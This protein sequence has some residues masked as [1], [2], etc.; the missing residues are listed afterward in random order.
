[1]PLDRISSG[2]TLPAALLAACLLLPGCS[3]PQAASNPE[4]VVVSEEAAPQ[5]PPAT[6]PLPTNTLY[7]LLAAEFAGIRNQIEPALEV[8]INQAHETRDPA[9]IERAVRIAS[10]VGQ[11]ELVLELSEL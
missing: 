3:T 5:A 6:R 7:E 9:V 8:Y 2:H 10:F 1:M 4:P 11:P